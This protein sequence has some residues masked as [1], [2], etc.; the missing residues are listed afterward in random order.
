MSS[1]IPKDRRKD[2]AAYAS[3]PSQQCQ[4]ATTRRPQPSPEGA[5][6]LEGPRRPVPKNPAADEADVVAGPVPVNNLPESF[7]KLSRRSL[8]MFRSLSPVKP[9]Q[10][11]SQKR[12]RFCAPVPECLTASQT[13]L[14]RTPPEEPN[15][16]PEEPSNRRRSWHRTGNTR[17]A[18]RTSP[19]P[20]RTQ[21][22][23]WDNP[24]PGG[25]HPRPDPAHATKPPRG[26]AD[27]N[28][29][30]PIARGF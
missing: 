6:G 8:E 14:E 24:R 23:T 1:P 12:C 9:K 28:P 16:A 27:I 18:P 2:T 29:P 3:L 13:L 22:R 4:R 15:T 5:S 20:D 11:R 21:A 19:P 7:S 10:R 30:K 17:S 26:G 25:K